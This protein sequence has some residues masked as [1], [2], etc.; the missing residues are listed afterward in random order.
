MLHNASKSLVFLMVVIMIAIGWIWPAAAQQKPVTL[1]IPLPLTGNFSEF[2]K[3]MKNSFEMAKE[4]V[5]QSGGINGRSLNIVYADDKGEVSFVAAAFDQLVADSKP[6]LLLGGYA[7][8]P[9]Y[10]LAQLSEKADMPFLICSASADKITQRGWKNIFRLNPP[11]SEYTKGLEDF[12]LKIAKPKSMAIINENS[13]FGTSGAI[14]MIEFCMDKAIEIRAHINYDRKM[15]L[16][17]GYLDALLAPLTEE[18]PGVI[19]MISYLDDA[20]ALVKQLQELNIDSLL[21]GGAGGFTLQEFIVK[22]GGVANYLL[23]ASLWSEHVRYPGAAEYFARYTNRFRSSPDYHGA[24]AYSAL[25]VA[26]EALKRSK[27]FSP[28]DIREAL[29]QIYMMTPFGPVKFYSYE[30]FERQN[31]VNTLVM[32][33][34]NGKFETI[35]PPETASFQ[36]IL[37]SAKID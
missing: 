7:S 33:I 28:Q 10:R 27:S 18:P 8:N 32:Q 23:T 35:W 17:P 30:D 26:A 6:A 5:N 14:R 13:M 9:T 36:F 2:G 29:N 1:G 25:L 22:A 12:W 15:V 3:M 34:V 16:T 31:S 20:V 19:Y 37:P 11:I 4:S 21:C 24:A